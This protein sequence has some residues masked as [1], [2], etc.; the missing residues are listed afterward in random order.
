[1]DLL[2]HLFFENPLTLLVFLGMAALVAGIAW[3]RS[4]SRHARIAAIVCVG[5]GVTVTLV[6]W[7]VETDREKIQRT[8]ATMAKAIRKGDADALL[9]RVSPQYQNGGADKTVLAGVVRT[10]L[11]QTWATAESAVIERIGAQARVTQVYQFHP[12]PG[13]RPLLPPGD[14]RVKWEG[15]FVRD[16][17]GQWRLFSVTAIEPSRITPEEAAKYV[18]PA[19]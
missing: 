7:A 1:M 3:M 8:L 19:A 18:R 14:D 10:A 4:G 11:K 12:A 16:T 2:E 9:E 15:V 13:C 6:A 5:I 17:D